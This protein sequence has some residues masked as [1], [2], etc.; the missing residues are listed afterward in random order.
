MK[1]SSEEN[2]AS[3]GELF[4]EEKGGEDCTPHNTDAFE[5]A[6]RGLVSMEVSPRVHTP[7]CN[8]K[9]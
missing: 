7:S 4:T 9:V 5:R 8:L 2:R 1:L 3:E 6:G